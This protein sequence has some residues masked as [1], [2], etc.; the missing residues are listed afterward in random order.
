MRPDGM[1]RLHKPRAAIH[2]HGQSADYPKHRIPIRPLNSY[3]LPF[4]SSTSRRGQRPLTTGHPDLSTST[5][6]SWR[7]L[8]P[9]SPPASA[10]IER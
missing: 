8:P 5:A 9:A 10:R 1:A 6:P 3:G 7:P 2:P 4:P